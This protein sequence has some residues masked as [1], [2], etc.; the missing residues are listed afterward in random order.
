MCNDDEG[1]PRINLCAAGVDNTVRYLQCNMNGVPV[2]M[3][4]PGHT[5]FINDVAICKSCVSFLFSSLFLF[6]GF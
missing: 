4:L 1:G 5:S 2:V 3:A 6:F